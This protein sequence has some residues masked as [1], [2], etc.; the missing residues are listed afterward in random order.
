[1]KLGLK[2]ISLDLVSFGTPY[3]IVLNLALIIFILAVLPTDALQHSPVKCVFKTIILPLVFHGS[4]PIYG[5]FA[6]CECPACGITR[7]VSSLLHGDIPG[8]YAYNPLSFLVL[9][10]MLFLLVLNLYRTIERLKHPK[11]KNISASA[12]RKSTK[13]KR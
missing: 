4:C 9:A 6:G 12:K 8:A 13:M 7:G 10:T 5:L 2:K 11:Q 3:A 1:V